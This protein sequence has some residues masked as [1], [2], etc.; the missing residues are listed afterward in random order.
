MEMEQIW[1]KGDYFVCVC[2]GQSSCGFWVDMSRE[3]NME[4]VSVGEIRTKGCH[5]A[6]SA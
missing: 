2:W 3:K 6:S 5:W 1:A 4:P